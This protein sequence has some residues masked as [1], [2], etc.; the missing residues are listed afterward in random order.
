MPETNRELAGLQTS[1]FKQR[2]LLAPYIASPTGA[3]TVGAG[4]TEKNDLIE[5]PYPFFF[6]EPS[7]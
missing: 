6:L 1:L 2:E 5:I 3:L 4:D 7:N